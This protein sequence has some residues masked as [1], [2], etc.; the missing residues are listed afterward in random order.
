MTTIRTF[1]NQL[2]AAFAVS[3]LQANGVDAVLLDE[4]SSA[5]YP[6]PAVGIRLQVPEDQLSAAQTWLA[7][8]S[9]ESAD[10]DTSSDATPTS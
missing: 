2:D 3:F 1:T 7:Q 9:S 4:A 10:P 8:L 6:G 5:N